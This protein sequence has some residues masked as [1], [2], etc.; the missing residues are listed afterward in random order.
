MQAFLTSNYQLF[1][2][3]RVVLHRGDTT[4]ALAEARRPASVRGGRSTS[5]TRWVS[6]LCNCTEVFLC[7]ALL[8]RAG[9]R[10]VLHLSASWGG[11]QPRI[12]LLENVLALWCS[13]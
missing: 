10:F 5:I 12:A 2:A 11:L 4:D 8:G 9:H 3:A 6:F 13:N 1:G 7:G